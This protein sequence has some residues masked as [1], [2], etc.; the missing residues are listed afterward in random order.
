MPKGIMKR[1]SGTIMQNSSPDA[2]EEYLVKSMKDALGEWQN[3]VKIKPFLRVD[4]EDADM[5]N[6]V[7]NGFGA[8]ELNVYGT[9]LYIPFMIVDKTLLPFDTIRL[10]EQEISYD[11]SKLRRVVNAIEHKAKEKQSTESEEDSF[12]TMELAD[13]NDIQYNNG[14]LGTIMQIRDQHKNMDARTNDDYRGSGFG[15][16]DEDRI[17]RYASEMDVLHEFHEVMDKVAQL[18]TFTP[19]QLEAYE[20][21]LIKQA[22]AEEQELFEKQAAEQL[23]ETIDAAKVRRDMAN[24]QNEKLFNVHRAAS[25]NN[26]AFPTFDFFKASSHSIILVFMYIY[27]YFTA[28]QSST[29][30][31]AALAASAV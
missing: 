23:T 29:A 14:F 20:R 12:Q 13:Y 7:K 21:Q 5:S 15:T 19:K 2:I 9:K 1:A 27:L 22:E 10:G 4:E 6:N 18:H 25:G 8:I 26:I 16:V 17:M 28:L 3:S 24:L 30:I 11:Y 31:C